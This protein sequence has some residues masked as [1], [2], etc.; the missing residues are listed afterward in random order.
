ML[1]FSTDA[2]GVRGN[3]NSGD[4]A[5]SNDGSILAFASLATNLIG[6]GADTN[7]FKDVFIKKEPTGG[8]STGPIIRASTATG[9]VQSNGDSGGD[10]AGRAV[11]LSGYGL[12]VVYHSVATNL[13]VGNAPNT[14]IDGNGL[15]DI[16]ESDVIW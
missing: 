14:T 10:Q 11:S 4:P 3:A 8:G 12:Q 5:I 16:F 6:S 2:A 1:R 13:L 7:G 15:K 9:G